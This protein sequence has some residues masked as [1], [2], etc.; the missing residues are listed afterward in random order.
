MN[1]QFS[2]LS[3]TFLPIRPSKKYCILIFV[4]HGNI[5]N[6]IKYLSSNL[7]TTD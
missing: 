1:D 7:V 5:Y 6:F 3:L 2:E 4:Y